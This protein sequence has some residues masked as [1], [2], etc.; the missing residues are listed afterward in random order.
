MNFWC[1][2]FYLENAF[3]RLVLLDF[4]GCFSQWLLAI[5]GAPGHYISIVLHFNSLLYDFL[6]LVF[7]MLVQWF[8][9]LAIWKLDIQVH[10][11]VKTAVLLV[12]Q[13]ALWTLWRVDLVKLRVWDIGELLW[14]PDHLW[15]LCCLLL[16]HPFQLLSH[17]LNF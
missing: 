11:L 16:R 4:L 6:V 5:F 3:S 1:T 2:G 8:L 15:I 10:Q 7:I 13:A 12:S 17:L 9:I 14:L